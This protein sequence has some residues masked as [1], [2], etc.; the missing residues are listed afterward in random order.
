[1]SPDRTSRPRGR[2]NPKPRLSVLLAAVSAA[3]N[4][5]RLLREFLIH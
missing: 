1:M 5:L 2:P 4:I 3:A